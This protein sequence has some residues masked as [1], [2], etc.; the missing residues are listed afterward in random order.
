MLRWQQRAAAGAPLVSLGCLLGL[1]AAT[2]LRPAGTQFTQVGR[3]TGPATA[4]AYPPSSTIG[5]FWQGVQRSQATKR[6]SSN[7]DSLRSATT[8][9]LLLPPRCPPTVPRLVM[10]IV[11]APIQCMAFRRSWSHITQK[12]SPVI[13]PLSAHGNSPSAVVVVHLV[14]WITAAISGSP[15]RLIFWRRHRTEGTPFGNDWR[16]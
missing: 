13:Q 6:L 16:I 3:R 11:V 7:V 2:T 9:Q 15:P 12:R 4:L 5:P 8:V 14:S 1:I 10:A